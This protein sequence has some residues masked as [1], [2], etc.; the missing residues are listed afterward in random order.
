MT[1][2]RA[3]VAHMSVRMRPRSENVKTPD[4]SDSH[5]VPQEWCWRL[6]ARTPARARQPPASTASA[7]H[8]PAG[9]RPY[10]VS[11]G[12]TRK[13]PRREELERA[14]TFRLALRRFHAVTDRAVRQAGLTSRQYLLLLVIESSPPRKPVR[15]GDLSDALG[16]VPSS[17]TELLDRAESAGILQRTSSAHDGRVTNVRST[18]E[19][20]RR[21]AR[22]FHDLADERRIVAGKALSLLADD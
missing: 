17:M 22:A 18:P 19:G 9:E 10:D 21:L 1:F 3:Q 5:P 7:V 6:S 2:K 11:V 8:G 14:A 4:L 16:L 20:R 12:T 13:A 15:I